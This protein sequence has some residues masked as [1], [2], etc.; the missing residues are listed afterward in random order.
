MRTILLFSIMLIASVVCAQNKLTV[1]VDGI[2]NP[3]GQVLVGVYDSTNFIKK[4]LYYGIAKVKKNK[5]SV[6]VVIKNIPPG[7]YAVATFHDENNNYKLDTGSFGIP[8]EKYGFSN[9]VRGKKGAPAYRDCAINIKDNT[10]INITVK[11]Y[12]KEK[13]GEKSTR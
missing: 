5:N 1:V 11:F 2:E 7:K 13:K 9:N 3:K 4:H 10:K 6:T 12:K 8:T